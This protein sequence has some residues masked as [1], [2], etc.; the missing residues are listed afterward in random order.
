MESGTLRRI[1]R[2]KMEEGKDMPTGAKET[3]EAKKDDSKKRKRGREERKRRQ[4][5]KGQGNSERI[6]QQQNKWKQRLPIDLT[7]DA[8]SPL[9]EI[10]FLL[11]VRFKPALS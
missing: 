10:A 9:D 6:E 5:W 7:K 2:G 8:A 3:N 4:E 11:T 1:G